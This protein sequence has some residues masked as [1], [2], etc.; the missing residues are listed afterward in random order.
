MLLW[1]TLKKTYFISGY[2]K[3]QL[4]VT[5][6]THPNRHKKWPG[7]CSNRF[8][9]AGR[10]PVYQENF[11]RQG[12]KEFPHVESTL[13]KMLGNFHLNIDQEFKHFKF[14]AADPVPDLSCY[15]TNQW[16]KLPLETNAS[17]IVQTCFI[18][19]IRSPRRTSKRSFSPPARRIS[20]WKYKISKVFFSFVG[21]ILAFLD[22]VSQL[23]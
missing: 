19:F 23:W 2:S 12:V 18:F 1:S 16:K 14:S 5:N 11:L 10:F 3:R 7:P 17:F 8:F 4:S 21:A 13:F 15:E 20:S 6:I 9:S 22:P